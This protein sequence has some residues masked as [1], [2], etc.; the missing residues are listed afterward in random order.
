MNKKSKTVI[1]VLL[2]LCM[3]AGIVFAHEECEKTGKDKKTCPPV[4][5][6]GPMGMMHGDEKRCRSCMSMSKMIE[7]AK[8]IG[9]NEEQISKINDLETNCKKDMIRK[10]AEIGILKVDKQALLKKDEV[11]LS[12]LKNIIQKIA[13][14]ESEIE[15]NCVESSVRVK[16]ILTEEQMKKLHE[17]TKT[18]KDKG[19]KHEKHEHGKK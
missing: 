4:T 9:L 6:N 19:E 5:Q 1:T 2:A 12:E 16:K 7:H 18:S 8:E 13:A 14:L 11:N 15:Y 17:L 10:Q 3:S